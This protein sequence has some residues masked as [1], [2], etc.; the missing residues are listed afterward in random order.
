MNSCQVR[1]DPLA[2]TSTRGE[3]R[4]TCAS[5]VSFNGQLTIAGQRFGSRLLLGTG[6]SRPK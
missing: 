4:L 1:T 3:L 6:S 5:D 2:V